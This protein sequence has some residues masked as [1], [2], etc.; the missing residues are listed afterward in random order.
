M[1]CLM[2]VVDVHVM[3]TS[4]FHYNLGGKR[5]RQDSVVAT[6]IFISRM[7]NNSTISATFKTFFPFWFLEN[8]IRKKVLKQFFLQF[9]FFPHLSRHKINYYNLTL[10]FPR[11][12][13]N[14]AAEESNRKRLFPFFQSYFFQQQSTVKT[15][16][17]KRLQNHIQKTLVFSHI[18]TILPIHF[19]FCL[20]FLPQQQPRVCITGSISCS[21][22]SASLE[23]NL[24][25]RDVLRLYSQALL[26][27]SQMSS[28]YCHGSWY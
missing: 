25:T 19:V 12:H 5:K 23:Q 9:S 26:N 27:I 4:E 14:P 8:S 20:T 24:Q 1:G 21:K 17:Q 11:L 7:K 15:Q 16:H 28:T 10:N 18:Y 2:S 13:D 6:F 22:T 3:I